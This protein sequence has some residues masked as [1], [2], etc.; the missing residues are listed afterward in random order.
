MTAFES[1]ALLPVI[2]FINVFFFFLKF[3]TFEIFFFFFLKFETL[4]IYHFHLNN[5][6]MFDVNIFVVTKIIR[7]FLFW[8][9]FLEFLEATLS[10]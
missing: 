1:N 5:R 2:F 9:K 4:E 10:L 3:L 7:E 6:L 8:K